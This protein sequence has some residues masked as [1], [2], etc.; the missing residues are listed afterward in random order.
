MLEICPHKYRLV[1][2]VGEP[3]SQYHGVKKNQ[4]AGLQFFLGG[5]GG[6]A[7]RR[8]GGPTQFAKI[9]FHPPS[10]VEEEEEEEEGGAESFILF[11]NDNKI[12]LHLW[13]SETRRAADAHF[14]K[15]LLGF[16]F[17]FLS[18]SHENPIPTSSSSSSSS[19]SSLNPKWSRLHLF[20]PLSTP[21]LYLH[22]LAI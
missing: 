12:R 21:Y 19:F 14:V 15:K 2:L 9:F 22:L 20:V 4:P 3:L 11:S 18:S 1:C 13:T 7:G 17:L 16:F 5:G 6:V 10:Q 8:R